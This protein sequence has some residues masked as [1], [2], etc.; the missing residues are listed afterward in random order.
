[1]GVPP[2]LTSVRGRTGLIQRDHHFGD[3]GGHFEAG[4]EALQTDGD[5]LVVPE[6]HAAK[7]ADEGP[8]R[9]DHTIG[10]G[11]IAEFFHVSG[12]SDELFDRSPRREAE[13]QPLD[14]ERIVAVTEGQNPLTAA[15]A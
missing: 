3:I 12:A 14:R 10:S 1:M 11:K 9:A 2:G 5:A 8:A 15:G 13:A 7:A 6:L 4:P